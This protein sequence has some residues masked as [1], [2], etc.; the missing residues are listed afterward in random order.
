ML[1]RSEDEDAWLNWNR[2]RTSWSNSYVFESKAAVEAHGGQPILRCGIWMDS[3]AYIYRFEN[4]N[5]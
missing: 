1:L 2:N 5:T 3:N 4:S